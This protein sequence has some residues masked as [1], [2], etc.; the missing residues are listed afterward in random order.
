MLGR[1]PP[2]KENPVVIEGLWGDLPNPGPHRLGGSGRV[3][4][5]APEGHMRRLIEV[6]LTRQGYDVQTFASLEEIPDRQSEPWLFIFDADYISEDEITAFRAEKA[7][8]GVSIQPFG[9][10]CSKSDRASF[11]EVTFAYKNPPTWM[12][13][14]FAIWMTALLALACWWLS[15][16]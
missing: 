16:R 12:L 7:W 14:K 6:N 3:I 1:P 2:S 5:V 8:E 4:V 13:T 10:R 15:R 9:R 11:A